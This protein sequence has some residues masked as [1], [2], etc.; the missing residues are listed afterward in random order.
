[1]LNIYFYYSNKL[2]YNEEMGALSKDDVI[3]ILKETKNIIG[4]LNMTLQIN[5]DPKIK[6]K[7]QK[8]FAKINGTNLIKLKKTVSMASLKFSSFLTKDSY[9]ILEDK[10]FKSYYILENFVYNYS[11]NLKNDTYDLINTIKKSSNYLL[12]INNC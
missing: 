9:K 1:M 10:M 11:N 7:L 2:T 3:Y 4:Q 12:N 6:S 5:F 8:Y